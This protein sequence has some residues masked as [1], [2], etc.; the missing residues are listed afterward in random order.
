M[1]H[2]LISYSGNSAIN[3]CVNHSKGNVRY[4]IWA[5]GWTYPNMNSA[6]LTKGLSP[7]LKSVTTVQ[8]KGKPHLLEAFFD[9]TKQKKMQQA[10]HQAHAELNQIFQTATVGM[11]L[12]DYNFNILKVNQTFSELSGIPPEEA[13]GRKCF[14]VFAGNMCHSADCSLRKVI[15]GEGTG[16]V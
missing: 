9:I 16:R 2:H 10:L 7:V 6:Q 11:R 8:F 15:E 14:D 12:I 3:S 5:R 4:W 1:D 13:V